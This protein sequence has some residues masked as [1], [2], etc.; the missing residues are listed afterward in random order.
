MGAQQHAN[1]TLLVSSVHGSP[2]SRRTGILHP[3]GTR[4]QYPRN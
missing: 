3:F 4:V 2:A 1:A